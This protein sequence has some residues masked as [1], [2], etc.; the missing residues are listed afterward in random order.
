VSVVDDSSA[1]ALLSAL[2][3]VSRSLSERAAQLR[4]EPGWSEVTQDLEIVGPIPDEKLP[5]DVREALSD[6]RRQ[7]HMGIVLNGYVDAKP[8][9]QHGAAWMFDVVD[10][11]P[12]GWRVSRD[13][14]LYPLEG[15]DIIH[16]LD[17][18]DFPNRVELA[19]ALPAL[20]EELLATSLP[21]GGGAARAG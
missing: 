20:I 16:R 12:T 8:A 9:D 2:A 6:L 3:Q 19:T 15:D 17:D 13:V 1:T 18:V 14:T 11:S 7:G 5:P 10:L 21:T 4:A